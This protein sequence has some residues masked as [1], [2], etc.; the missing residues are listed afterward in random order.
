MHIPD[1]AAALAEVRRV[2]KPGGIIACR[3]AIVASSFLDPGSA[4]I[5]RAW[6]VSSNLLS[7]YG[8]HPELGKELKGVLLAAGFEQVR[9]R[10]SF[11][12]SGTDDDVDFFHGFIVDWF[13]SP[14]V[15]AAAIKN[16]L[17][18]ADEF[19]RG[20]AAL[21]AWRSSPG[22]WVRSRSASAWR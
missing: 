17:S 18:T 16:G 13:H 19:E 4:E 22:R 11:E 5:D 20:R 7:A 12:C 1:T 15:V 10:F 6:T 21:E 9:P 2:L 8:G 3:E 14:P